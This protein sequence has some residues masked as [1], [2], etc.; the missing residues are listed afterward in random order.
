[1]GRVSR[2][3]SYASGDHGLLNIG[4]GDGDCPPRGSP[5]SSNEVI[6]SSIASRR[7]DGVCPRP[8]EWAAGDGVL[9]IVT[10]RSFMSRRVGTC[11]SM[12][13]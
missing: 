1:M 3:L 7:G 8:S 10:K 5:I 6:T 12:D 2:K 4:C 9:D 11:G 13:G